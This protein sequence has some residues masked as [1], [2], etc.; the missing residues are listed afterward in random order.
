MSSAEAHQGLTDLDQVVSWRM[1]C[2]EA[3]SRM[4]VRLKYTSCRSEDARNR[5]EAR[6]SS[7][8]SLVEHQRLVLARG[9][10]PASTINPVKTVADEIV[11]M[12]TTA[13]GRLQ[14]SGWRGSEVLD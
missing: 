13:A 6:V 4:W 3:V 10:V 2:L 1:H 14:S 11:Q 7:C 12:L 5:F 8:R 9:L